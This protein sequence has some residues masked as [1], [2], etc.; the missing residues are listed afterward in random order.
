MT[1][2]YCIPLFNKER[3]IKAVLDATVAECLATGG[4]IIV[5]DDA[6][7]D[8]SRTIAGQFAKHGALRLIEGETNRGVFAAT[9]RLVDEAR[10]PFLRLVDADDVILP[11]STT[12]LLAQL[13]RQQALLVHGLIGW[14]GRDDSIPDYALASAEPVPLRKLLRNMDF[15]LSAALLATDAAR[16]ASPLPDLQI[17]QDFCLALRLA[18]RKPLVRSTALVSLQPAERASGNSLSRRMAA[19]YRDICLILAQEC[20]SGVNSA[21]VAF[22]VRRQASRCRRYFRRHVPSGL[23]VRET[24]FL[25]TCNLAHESEPASAHAHRLHRIARIFD[26]DADR[27]LS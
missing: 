22:V 20:L 23:G 17:S 12:Y 1:V 6:S 18:K 13:R 26:S 25:A 2:S 4:E 27:I 16:A 5:Y 24:L 14:Q 19:M 9:T 11:G 15:N 7:T 10:Q 21:D 3:H 8:S